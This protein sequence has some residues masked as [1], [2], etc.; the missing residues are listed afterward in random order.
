MLFMETMQSTTTTRSDRS[1]NGAE[2]A[3]KEGLMASTFEQDCRAFAA[4]FP[5]PNVLRAVALCAQ[6]TLTWEQVSDLFTKSLAKGLAA[7]A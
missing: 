2:S 6:G 4:E 3:R 7:V 5:T 1:A